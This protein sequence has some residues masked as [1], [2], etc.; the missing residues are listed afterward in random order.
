MRT[1]L[2][3]RRRLTKALAMAALFS[4]AWMFQSCSEDVLEGQ[5]SWLG[6]SIY[7]RLQDDGNYKYTIRLIDDLD[8]TA[9]FSQTGSKTLF[10]ADDAAFETF[11]QNNSW[12]VHSY[13]QLSTAQKKL[14]LNAETVN[15]AYL[16]ELLANVS[17]NPPLEGQCMRREAAVTIYD[18]VARILPAD[19]P[20]TSYW[21][22]ARAKQNGIV[23]MRDNTT[24]TMIHFIPQ[25][26]SNNN[27]TASDL[28][29]LTNGEGT[30]VSEAWISGKKVIDR[31]ITCKNGYIQKVEG[32]IT[33]N[34]NMA[35]TIRKHAVMSR[36]SS[37]L[38]RYSAPYYDETATRNYDRL[39]NTTDSVFV[40]R[41]F[42]ET[43]PLGSGYGENDKHFT[44]PKG[45][46]VNDDYLLTFD[47]GWNQYMYANT[48][49]RDFHYD[50]GVMLVPRND[51][52]EEWFNSGSGRVLK[53]M[54]GTWENVPLNVLTQLMNIN[55]SNSF[56]EAVPSKF[57]NIVDNSTKQPIGIQPSDVDSCFMASNGV[58]YLLNK[59][60]TPA[61]YSS[62]S[63]PVI[64]HAEDNMRVL[65]WGI[66]HLEYEPYLNSMD[67]RYSFIIPVDNALLTYVDP[68][69]YISSTPI[70]YQFYWDNS[71]K[72]IR[73]NRYYCTIENGEVTPDLTRKLQDPSSTEISNRLNDLINNLIII[74]DVE[75]GSS[76]YKTK[77]GSVIKVNNAGV[78]G[79]MT[80]EGGLQMELN[81]PILVEGDGNK[82]DA[83]YDM[84]TDGGNGKSYVL[85][86]TT[87]LP[88]RK[89]T[90]TILQ[91]HPEYSEFLDLLRMSDLLVTNIPNS[92]TR[93]LCVDQNISLFDNYNYTVYVPTN[94]AIEQLQADSILPTRADA[95]AWESM[96]S[97]NDQKT[98]QN[99]IGNIINNFLRYH[100]QDNSV[101]VDGENQSDVRY[102]SSMLNPD[103][104]RYYSIGV[105]AGKTGMTLTDNAGNTRHVVTTDGLY[106]NVGREYWVSGNGKND[107]VNHS[108]SLYQANDLVVHQIDG[109]LFYTQD[110][111]NR[112][113]TDVV[114]E[115][116]GQNASAKRHSAS[117]KK[118]RR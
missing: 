4:G 5:P 77:G 65:N 101:F 13:D 86:S 89:S 69:S 46:N 59:V 84:T 90:Y 64:V 114:R 44:D 38:D 34:D 50:A 71:A 25:F 14:L 78:A 53:D 45:Q 103:T 22:D 95:E 91:E 27:I 118:W 63:F 96:Y 112:K 11:F 72:S 15:N 67:S 52:L 40:L 105:T 1:K 80:V 115:A 60:F 109:A 74:G 43:S 6:N 54:Y 16:I 12:G 88:S 26:M 113:W 20:P 110:E 55:M 93:Y 116:L 49:D 85:Q 79:S 19:M 82:T 24:P 37:L 28:T 81:A 75:D 108:S 100:I 62:V 2:P 10:A 68:C 17:G 66:D 83:I 58:V 106:N 32:V 23:L 9:V 30:S 57:T 70:M 104:K 107:L 102:E 21:D 33:P 94:E 99:T 76:Y 41:Y 56:I 61:S 98:V 7:E 8:Q 51:K 47:P 29:I 31:D 73:A 42:A 35:E 117:A 3:T 18:S 36:Y 111:M 92:S 48:S 87:V 39:N 97:G